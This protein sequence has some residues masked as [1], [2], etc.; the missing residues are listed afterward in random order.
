MKTLRT[1]AADLRHLDQSPLVV[2][3]GD[4]FTMYPEM[5]NP[6]AVVDCARLLMLV[7][8]QLEYTIENES[9]GL[10]SPSMI[11]VPSWTRRHWLSTGAGGG[12]VAYVEFVAP[13]ERGF[14]LPAL[15]SPMVNA[16]QEHAALR[17]VIGLIR[18]GDGPAIVAS[19]ELKAILAR[20]FC[21]ARAVGGFRGVDKSNADLHVDA[22]IEWLNEHL[23]DADALS[24]LPRATRL[25]RDHLRRL[26]KKHTGMPPKQYLIVQRMRAA[27]F[28]LRATDLLVKEVAASTGYGDPF[29]F[30]RQYR[31]FWGC[32]P[33][34]E[35]KA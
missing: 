35:R 21:Q 14:S 20:F 31:K 7:Q 32:S 28:Q 23:A 12:R 15:A 29:H 3:K 26:F 1:L 18:E 17:R 9:Y 27:R 5:A 13:N 11:F 19:I 30:S 2:L 22:A 24:R 16:E 25:S 33:A 6:D 10:E 4:E 34:S 8:G